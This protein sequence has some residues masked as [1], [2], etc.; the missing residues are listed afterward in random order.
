MQDY[1]EVE[2]IE[3]GDEQAEPIR[4]RIKGA[5][6]IPLRG[7]EMLFVEHGEESGFEKG[8][9][10]PPC[11][12][13]EPDIDGDLRWTAK[14]ELFEETG[15]KVKIENVRFYR[16]FKDL[17]VHMKS[18]IVSAHTK[19]Y[20]CDRFEGEIVDRLPETRPFW[21]K[22]EDYLSGGVG[23]NET[24]IGLEYE[25]AVKKALKSRLETLKNEKLKRKVERDMRTDKYLY[26]NLNIVR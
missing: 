11:G 17:S 3:Q 25:A 8:K 9:H 23:L 21:F 7:D 12:T 24:Y 19:V 5:V 14:R 2:Q 10:T 13:Y 22:I 15:L 18:G 26:G 4:P 20:F 6:I 16:E 1:D